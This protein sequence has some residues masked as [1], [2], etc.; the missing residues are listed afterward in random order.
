MRQ[1]ISE[2]DDFATGVQD[3]GMLS[4]RELVDHNGVRLCAVVD[5]Y[6]RS[7]HFRR[8]VEAPMG[9]L[10]TTHQ[11]GIGVAPAVDANGRNF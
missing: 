1:G 6:R 7:N 4:I 10:V 3:D 2:P 8:V 9:A 5:E 11:K